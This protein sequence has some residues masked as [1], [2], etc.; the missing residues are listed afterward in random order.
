[1]APTSIPTIDQSRL[2]SEVARMR[3]LHDVPGA[4][5][6]TFAESAARQITDAFWRGGSTAAV[7]QA[8]QVGWRA[9][10]RSGQYD[11]ADHITRSANDAVWRGGLE[12]RTRQLLDELAQR[13]NRWRS[14]AR[15]DAANP[16]LRARRGEVPTHGIVGTL[17]RYA[18][19]HP[20]ELHLTIG[21]AL[22]HGANFGRQDAARTTHA[23]LASQTRS[24]AAATG[25]DLQRVQV[26]G[27]RGDDW[28]ADPSR[29]GLRIS[30]V[31]H[32]M[33]RTSAPV[34]ADPGAP[35]PQPPSPSVA[36]H[37]AARPQ[38]GSGPPTP[39]RAARPP[40]QAPAANRPRP[41][42]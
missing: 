14:A 7:E 19:R 9:G 31:F 1:M 11:A 35:A 22:S 42:R 16:D 4:E 26:A 34:R 20:G 21:Q 39:G 30:D 38:P 29:A 6:A 36:V 24:Q 25:I 13:G 3:V 18:Q 33:A 37:R 27:S 40:A 41:T 23:H 12:P 10:E 28:L 8:W 17:A 15:S 2:A 32:G 5:A